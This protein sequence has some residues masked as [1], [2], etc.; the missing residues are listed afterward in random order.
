L[1]QFESSLRQAWEPELPAVPAHLQPYHEAWLQTFRGKSS[2]CTSE[3]FLRAIHTAPLLLVSDYHAC[4]RSR[5]GLATLLASLPQDRPLHLVLELLPLGTTLTAQLAIAGG[6]PPLVTG[7]KL[8]EAYLPVLEVLAARKG[9]IVGAWKDGSIQQR[10]R[11]IADLLGRLQQPGR[12]AR[13]VFHGG[14]WHLAAAHLPRLLNSTG[15]RPTVVHQSPEPLW[16]RRGLHQGA[17]HLRLEQ[18]DHWAWMDTPPLHLW[19]SLLQDMRRDDEEEQQESMSHLITAAAECLGSLMGLEAPTVELTTFSRRRWPEFQRQLPNH[20]KSALDPVRPPRRDLF[21]PHRPWLWMPRAADLNLLLRA[22][23]HLLVCDQALVHE[24]SLEAEMRRATFRHLAARVANPFLRPLEERTEAEALFPDAE[25]A[26]RAASEL[27][28]LP[29]QALDSQ[30][31]GPELALLA[32]RVWGSRLADGL[33]AQPR[34]SPEDMRQ[35]LFGCGE[36]F[37]W[38]GLTA[39]ILA[40]D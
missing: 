19:A 23:A 10:D 6:S 18:D 36:G 40:A 32:T 14:D 27:R 17:N 33:L 11:I 34:F 12:P 29:R 9:T 4:E 38:K 31:L 28:R 22:A 13:T 3:E 7:E 24:V 15:L 5:Q 30:L 2:E 16:R 8:E 26:R 21:H 25:Q 39:T 20:W 35:L 1:A 37:D